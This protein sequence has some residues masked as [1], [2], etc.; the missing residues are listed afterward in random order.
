MLWKNLNIGH[1]DGACCFLCGDV[2]NGQGKVLEGGP[3]IGNHRQPSAYR[4][5]A[6][7][8]MSRQSQAAIAVV[9]GN[10]VMDSAR[11]VVVPFGGG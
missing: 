8:N 6:D 7:E 10:A 4:H 5:Q 9:D 1:P 11:R 2:A 3:N